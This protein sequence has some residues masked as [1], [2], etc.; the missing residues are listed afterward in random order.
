MA[1]LEM[2]KRQAYLERVGHERA[3]EIWREYPLKD[4]GRKWDIY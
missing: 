3:K 2:V 4:Y 1:R